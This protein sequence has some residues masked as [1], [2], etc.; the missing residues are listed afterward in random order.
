MLSGLSRV[1]L[2]Y[3]PNRFY[4]DVEIMHDRL[5]ALPADGQP[6]D[7]PVIELDDV[8]VEED[9]GP[10]EGQMNLSQPAADDGRYDGRVGRGGGWAASNA[11]ATATSRR[12][13]CVGA[14]MC[15]APARRAACERCNGAFW[16]VDCRDEGD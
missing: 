2:G 1:R 10:A 11:R 6:A 12:P 14:R 13:G 9:R 8:S 3:A 15:V 4:A 7:L 16:V 5:R